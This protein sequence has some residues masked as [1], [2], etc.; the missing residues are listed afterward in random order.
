MLLTC[1]NATKMVMTHAKFIHAWNELCE[2]INIIHIFWY[3]TYG[4]FFINTVTLLHK[5]ICCKI[6]SHKSFILNIFQ[7]FLNIGVIMTVTIRQQVLFV[8]RCPSSFITHQFDIY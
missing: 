8:S 6:V 7:I 3:K 4:K 2:N 5:A 1:G